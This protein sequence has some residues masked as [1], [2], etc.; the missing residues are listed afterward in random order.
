MVLARCCKSLVKTTLIA[1]L[2]CGCMKAW[3]AVDQPYSEDSPGGSMSSWIGVAMLVG[4]IVGAW[5]AF[6]DTSEGIGGILLTGWYAAMAFAF[7]VAILEFIY[8]VITK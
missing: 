4:F 3:C 5:I 2:F 1:W 6:K 8:V 7:V